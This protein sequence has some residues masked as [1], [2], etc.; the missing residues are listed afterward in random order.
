[1]R[2]RTKVSLALLAIAPASWLIARF[3]VTPYVVFGGSM[4]PTLRSWDFCLMLRV[5][6]YEP[7]RG[8]I[9]MFSTADDP[10]LYFVKRVIALPGET[11]A[12][13]HGIVTVNGGV[14]PEPYAEANQTW[15]M[16]PT[17]VAVNKMFVLGDNRDVPLDAT[18]HG[19]V[20]TRLVQ[21]RLLWQWRWK[22]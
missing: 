12:I 4:E 17:A 16:K 15:D 1:M 10:P 22:K 19:L 21:A 3:V 20:A 7:R 5:R 13:A 9:V 8:E 18:L 11:V 6:R 14:L 2:C